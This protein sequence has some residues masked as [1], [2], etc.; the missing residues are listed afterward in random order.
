MFKYKKGVSA[1]VA[2]V[3]IILLVVVGVGLLWAAI[4]PQIEQVDQGSQ[5]DCL[6]VSLEPVSCLI[7]T[8]STSTST[9]C[10]EDSDC[11]SPETCN[12]N[13]DNKPEVNVKRNAGQGTM[14]GL[15]LIIDGTGGREI[16]DI[17]GSIAELG[18]QTYTL[19]GVSPNQGLSSVTAATQFSVAAVVGADAQTCQPLASPITCT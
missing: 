19:D 18:S 1:V 17:T 11:L 7:K 4:R 16:I 10:D 13:A 14:S 15:K 12:I 3:L 2:N 5:S 8:C 6:K 9:Y